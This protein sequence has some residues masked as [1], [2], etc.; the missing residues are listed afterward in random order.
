M[1]EL[2]GLTAQEVA[3]RQERGESN[4]VEFNTSRTYGQIIRKNV[5]HTVNIILFFLGGTLL[6]ER[7]H[8][9]LR[10]TFSAD[11][12][13]GQRTPRAI[14]HVSNVD[15][16]LEVALREMPLFTRYVGSTGPLDGAETLLGMDGAGVEKKRERKYRR[17]DTAAVER[18]CSTHLIG[19]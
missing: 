13:G 9:A 15:E 11:G 19:R 6:L 3:E 4:D 17:E 12:R 18:A 8:D 16:D 10:Q 14:T 7:P 2:R 1:T 5:F